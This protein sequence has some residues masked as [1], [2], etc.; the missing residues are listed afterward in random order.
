[1]Q[2]RADVGRDC[3]NHSCENAL[4]VDSLPE[5]NVLTIDDV[6]VDDEF[7]SLIPP[8]TDEER[9]GLMVS[10]ERDGYRDSLVTWNG[11]LLDGH[12]RLDI[13]E[14]NHADTDKVPPDVI[15]MKFPGREEAKVWIIK[16]QFARRNLTPM[17][18]AELALLLEPV[19]KKQA[20]E[21]QKSPT[22]NKNKMTLM[23]SSKSVNTRAEIA[24]AAGVSEQTIAKAKVIKENA[25]PKL[26]QEVREGKKS[27]NKAHEEI[28]G[29]KRTPRPT[30][31]EHGEFPAEA[32]KNSPEVKWSKCWHDIMVMLNSTRDLGGI[33]KLTAKWGKKGLKDYC[34]RIDSVI[35]TLQQWKTDIQKELSEG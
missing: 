15:D 28:T 26:L 7:R 8:L 22:G 21:N 23:N 32:A 25:S 12:N 16:N 5:T 30:G 6:T 34:K 10:I 20:K 31:D 3:R 11:I 33:K 18:R 24:K 4:P 27:I 9:T 17:Q 35:A 14:Q 1:M 13:Y 2:E 19:V 29:K